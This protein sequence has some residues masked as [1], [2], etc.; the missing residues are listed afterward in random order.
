MQKDK[1]K[2]KYYFLCSARQDIG[3]LIHTQRKILNF[4]LLFF[5]I[6]L[7]I[8]SENVDILKNSKTKIVLK[9]K[10]FV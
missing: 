4:Y 2:E 6:K 9:K 3:L 10:P 8:I 7:K 1:R 5:P